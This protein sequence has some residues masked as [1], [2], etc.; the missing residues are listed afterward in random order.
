MDYQGIQHTK[1]TKTN[2]PNGVTEQTYE[3][4]GPEVWESII[5]FA[6]KVMGLAGQLCTKIIPGFGN[7]PSPEVEVTNSQPADVLIEPKGEIIV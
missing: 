1:L 5:S 3:V 6:G 7:T 4:G 2:L